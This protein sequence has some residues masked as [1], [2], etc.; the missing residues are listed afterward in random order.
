MS[1]VMNLPEK[2]LKW[3]NLPEAVDMKDDMAILYMA[4]KTNK[5]AGILELGAGAGLSTR[6]LALAAQEISLESGSD[7]CMVVSVDIDNVRINDVKEKLKAEGLENQVAFVNEDSVS[8]VKRNC[9]K[10][11]DFFFIDTDHTYKQTLAEIVLAAPMLSNK[12]YIFM[13]DTRY[14]EVFDAIQTF[15]RQNCQYIYIDYATPAGLGLLMKKTGYWIP[16]NS[17]EKQ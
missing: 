4:V 13:H 8:F 3:Q 9:Q 12:G 14:I 17:V 1:A 6:A 11:V 15:L 2:I 7:P 16:L 5:P 10:I